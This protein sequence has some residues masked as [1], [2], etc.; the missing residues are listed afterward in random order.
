MRIS[1]IL[2]RDETTGKLSFKTPGN[3]ITLL[4][5]L[6]LL[7]VFLLLVGILIGEVIYR[8][9][10]NFHAYTGKVLEIKKD[11]FYDWFSSDAV[12]YSRIIVQTPDNK[13]ITRIVSDHILV[14]HD[15]KISDRIFKER[16]MFKQP[17][18][19]D[20]K[21]PQELMQE[22]QKLKDNSLDRVDPP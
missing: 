2:T 16:G 5:G 20:K 9:I 18:R 13:K 15:I 14:L 21:T 6:L 22:F 3:K 10:I 17:Y 7:C 8:T 4:I 19:C 12:T 11:W 1:F